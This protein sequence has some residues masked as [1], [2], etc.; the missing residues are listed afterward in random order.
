MTTPPSSPSTEIADVSK[1][2]PR[3]LLLH[4]SHD[5]IN[6]MGVVAQDYDCELVGV[7]SIEAALEALRA[8]N[9]SGKYF[10]SVVFDKALPNTKED[11]EKHA[12]LFA[13]QLAVAVQTI[14]DAEH[15]RSSVGRIPNDAER[16]SLRAENLRT[17][18]T[19]NPNGGDA[20]ITACLE[21]DLLAHTQCVQC[22]P[23]S[24]S[25]GNATALGE[26]MNFLPVSWIETV[27]EGAI[28][29]LKGGHGKD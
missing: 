20:F 26:K 11:A 8:A 19:M 9:T 5:T 27:F 18:R 1:P 7:D 25:K 21:D 23:T 17:E 10:T 16:I 3:I 22:E 14:D 6:E 15:D 4:S 29:A 12:K 13:E 28:A 24:I 2:K